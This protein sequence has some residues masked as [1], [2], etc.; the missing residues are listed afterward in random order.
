MHESGMREEI[1]PIPSRYVA[2]DPDGDTDE[3][4]EPCEG[5]I[6]SA[7]S[8]DDPL[9]NRGVV[10]EVNAIKAV[11]ESGPRNADAF[12]VLDKVKP[13]KTGSFPNQPRNGSGTIPTTIPNVEHLLKSYGIQVQYDVI[14]KK[15]R[16]VIPGHSGSADNTDNVAMSQI[17]SLANLNGISTGLIPS[18]VEAVGDRHQV[19]LVADWIT[20]KPWDGVDRLQALCDTLVQ[21]DD[22]PEPLKQQLL[23]RWLIGAVA[24]VF[25]PNGCR[26]RGVLTLQ[27]PQSIGKTEFVKSLM[28]DSILRDLVVK[29]DHHLDPSNKDSLISAV[30]HWIVEIGELDSSFKKDV[31]RLKGFLTSGQDKVRRPYART[32]SEYPRRTVFCATVNDSNFLVDPTGNT[33]WWTIPVVKINFKHGIDMQQLFAQIKVDYNNGE[34][35]WLLQHEEK[36]LEQHNRDHRAI[37]AIRERIADVLD[38]DRT[39]ETN[40]PAMTATE[41]LE[42][43]GIK[44]PTNSQARECG[45]VL[46]EF[47]GEPKKIKGSIKWR[48][49]KREYTKVE[50]DDDDKY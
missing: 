40:L 38:L 35:W 10:N 12:F 26:V 4:F 50:L 29:L 39:K 23:H 11:V 34:Q 13:L 8:L 36:L 25:E 44:S 18:F 47:L 43:I 33:R 16:I 37:S 7:V 17:I 2:C 6:V 5:T 24:A 14:K 22:Y 45:A 46:R 20:S 27:G 41:L 21:R 28:S 3:Q 1:T 49:P 15:L 9:V 30:T 48:I 42:G 32:E 31:A 19:N